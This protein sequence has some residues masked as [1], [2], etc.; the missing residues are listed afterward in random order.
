MQAENEPTKPRQH[1]PASELAPR[2]DVRVGGSLVRCPYCHDDVAPEA[3]G[4][5]ACRGCLARHHLNCWKETLAC[6]TCG[7]KVCMDGAVE[8]A[9]VERPAQHVEHERLWVRRAWWGLTVLGV[10]AT[11]AMSAVF[12]RE[13]DWEGA[14][15]GLASCVVWLGLGLGWFERRRVRKVVEKRHE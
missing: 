4:W 14:L 10:P 15:W 2:A 5:V 7:H 3:T 12:A 9:A 11:L 1:E 6:G 13:H 8:Y